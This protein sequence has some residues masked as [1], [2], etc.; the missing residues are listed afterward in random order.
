M[1]SNE[2]R[3][4]YDGGM[5]PSLDEALRRLAEIGDGKSLGSGQM[6]VKPYR[7]D[8]SWRFPTNAKAAAFRQ[9]VNRVFPSILKYDVRAQ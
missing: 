4:E 3:V 6:L 8:L 5:N 9:F 7:R 2:I 1:M